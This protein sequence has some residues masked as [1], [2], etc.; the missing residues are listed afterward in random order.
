[1]NKF[2][3]GL[4]HS[5]A[6]SFAFDGQGKTVQAEETEY[7]LYE[8]GSFP[9]VIFEEELHALNDYCYMLATQVEREAQRQRERKK[10]MEI[11]R[12]D[13]SIDDEWLMSA[14]SERGKWS[15][16]SD[17]TIPYTVILL[18]SFLEKTMKYI[19]DVFDKENRFT[20]RP[21]IKRPYLYSW[22]CSVL[23]M[24]KKEFEREYPSVFCILDECR[25]IR[26]NF[27]H[28]SLEGVRLDGDYAY[29]ERKLDPSFRLIDFISAITFILHETEKMYEKN[30]E[31]T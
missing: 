22:I 5:S 8:A 9:F 1:M 18:H 11:Q 27:A 24:S 4:K 23:G 17:I 20:D 6:F 12:Q 2:W 19:F 31:N 30:S 28:E 10:E 3:D 7:F 25:K 14:E 13:R 21:L 15:W 29:E 26:N 16:L